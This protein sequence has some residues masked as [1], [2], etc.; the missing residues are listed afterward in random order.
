VSGTMTNLAAK[1][2]PTV[3]ATAGMTQLGLYDIGPRTYQLTLH[4]KF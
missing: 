2:P 4:A 3:D 1:V